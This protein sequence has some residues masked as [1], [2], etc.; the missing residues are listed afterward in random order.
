MNLFMAKG[1]CLASKGQW[2]E[3]WCSQNWERPGQRQAAHS[4]NQLRQ[5]QKG[6]NSLLHFQ[7]MTPTGAWH[8]LAQGTV[9]PGTG[10]Y[11]VTLG[12]VDTVSQGLEGDPLDWH[13]GDAALSIVIPAVDLLGEPKVCHAHRHVISQPGGK[14]GSGQ[15]PSHILSHTPQAEL[16]VSKPRE[17][18]LKGVE[19]CRKSTRFTLWDGA[20]ENTHMQF[21]AAK[22]LW[23]KFRLLRYSMPRAM[24]TMNFTRVC[25]GTNWGGKVRVTQR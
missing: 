5:Q 12:G 10:T 21:R 25:R 2:A 15:P 23:R 14:Q 22:S 11:H 6:S 1:H 7:G 16:C 9:P 24:S 20:E 13:L 8:G 18:L 3:L 19:L 17:L 4:R